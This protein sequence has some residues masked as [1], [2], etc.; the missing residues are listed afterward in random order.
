[1]LEGIQIYERVALSLE[2]GLSSHDEG[3][4]LQC[5]SRQGSSE[6]SE[7]PLI[8]QMVL[9]LTKFLS[10]LVH[11]VANRFIKSRIFVLPSSQL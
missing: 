6:E 9:I 4:K 8:V 10:L 1:M 11:N 3:K 7:I 5:Q 2:S